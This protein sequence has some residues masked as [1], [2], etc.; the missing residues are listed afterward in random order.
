MVFLAALFT[1]IGCIEVLPQA[2]LILIFLILL[3]LMTIT[4]A[5][6]LHAWNNPLFV[7]DRRIRGLLYYSA[8]M[9]ALA[10]LGLL[11]IAAHKKFKSLSK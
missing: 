2:T 8:N 4:E 9:I 3:S 6:S 7:S 5:N 1:L 11:A 10:D